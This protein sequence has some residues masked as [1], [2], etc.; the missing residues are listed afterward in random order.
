[1]IGNWIWFQYKSSLSGVGFYKH[2]WMYYRIG[3]L[4]EEINPDHR[5]ISITVFFTFQ[6]W[7][8]PVP[9]SAC[10][11]PL[12]S[13]ETVFTEGLWKNRTGLFC[14]ICVFPRWNFHMKLT[15]QNNEF[16]TTVEKCWK[17]KK[18]FIYRI[19]LIVYNCVFHFFISYFSTFFRLIHSV[20]SFSTFYPLSQRCGKLWKT[21]K[22]PLFIIFFYTFQYCG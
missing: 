15:F 17:F 7:W 14:M 19:F 22:S 5:L 11:F 18:A 6:S 16:S 21:A 4:P 10:R 20:E 8:F 9:V 2:A 3:Q 12:F 1:M 13:G